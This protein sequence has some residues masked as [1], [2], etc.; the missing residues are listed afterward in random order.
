[1]MI[2]NHTL[3]AMLLALLSFGSM[4]SE[5]ESPD[6]AEAVNIADDAVFST[7]FMPSDEY[8]EEALQSELFDGVEI[9]AESL[10][11]SLDGTYNELKE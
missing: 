9:K 2:K 8:A 1:M 10:L 5:L 4:A 3:M 11:E 6:S 7:T